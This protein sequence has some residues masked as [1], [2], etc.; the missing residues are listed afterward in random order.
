MLWRHVN[1]LRGRRRYCEEG[2]EGRAGLWVGVGLGGEEDSVG[3]EFSDGGWECGVSEVALVNEGEV[4]GGV[5]FSQAGE[6]WE[7]HDGVVDAG[8]DED[9][10]G[11][12]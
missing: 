8:S 12:A 7:W 1:G 6:R 4:V 11:V 3:F 9:F 10:G 5:G 2:V